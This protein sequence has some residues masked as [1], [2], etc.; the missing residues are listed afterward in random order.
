MQVGDEAA[1]VDRGAGGESLERARPGRH[2]LLGELVGAGGGSGED[3][4]RGDRARERERVRVVGVAE[5]LELGQRAVG[6]RRELGVDERLVGAGGA[7]HRLGR[8][9]DEDV[10]RPLRGDRLGETDDLGRVAQVDAD[11]PQS[12]QPLGASRAAW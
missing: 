8:V 1:G 9:V 3:R 4:V 6:Q 12:M 11:D 5:G 2:G 7:A 10:E